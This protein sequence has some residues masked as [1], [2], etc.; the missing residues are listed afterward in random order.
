MPMYRG[1]LV[2][3]V[4]DLV[5]PLLHAQGFD[6]VELQLQQRKGQWLVRIFA[7]VEG[8]ISLED[9]QKLSR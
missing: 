9:C 7:D 5:Q 1:M 2:Q 3:S 4:T 8:G 6:L